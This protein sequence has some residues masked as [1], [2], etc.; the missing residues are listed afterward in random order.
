MCRWFVRMNLRG[1]QGTWDYGLMGAELKNNEAGGK[2]S[3]NGH[4]GRLHPHE[5][6]R[7]TYTLASQRLSPIRSTLQ[8]QEGFRADHMEL[9]GK[10][11]EGGVHD[12]TEPRPFNSMLTTVGPI[13]SDENIAYLRPETAQ[14]IFVNFKNVLDSTNR[15]PPFM[16]RKSAAYCTKTPKN[17]IF[18]VREFEQMEIESGMPHGRRVSIAGLWT[19]SPGITTAS[20]RKI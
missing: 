9:N 8:M 7:P 20:V 3:A 14:G 15:K 12:F 18:R 11:P 13:E 2:M 16:R 19:A 5:L 4:E 1:L 10:C 6:S 17:F